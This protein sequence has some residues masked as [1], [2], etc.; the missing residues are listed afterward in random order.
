[1]VVIVPRIIS[2]LVQSGWSVAITSPNELISDLNTD[3]LK[4]ENLKPE[5]LKTSAVQPE[6]DAAGLRSWLRRAM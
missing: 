5:N 2:S 6:I 4:L 3:Y 1:V